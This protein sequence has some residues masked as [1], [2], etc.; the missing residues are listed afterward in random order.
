MLCTAVST[1]QLVQRGG[2]RPGGPTAALQVCFEHCLSSAGREKE[3][4]G[5]RRGRRREK[6]GEEGE[7]GEGGRRRE[8]WERR[9]RERED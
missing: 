5:G 1:P 4:E 8:K 2:D 3:G 9:G 6:E 7:E